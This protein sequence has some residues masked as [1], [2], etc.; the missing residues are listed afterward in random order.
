[1]GRP[2]IMTSIHG[3][4]LTSGRSPKKGAIPLSR[5]RIA[6][7][8]ERNFHFA[9]PKALDIIPGNFAASRGTAANLY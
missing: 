7:R 3:R 8:R 5:G 9:K 6:R 4:S 1:M 2:H